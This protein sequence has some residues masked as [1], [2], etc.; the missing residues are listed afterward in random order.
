M[1]EDL[2]DGDQGD[3]DDADMNTLGAVC[4]EQG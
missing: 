1:T 4:E 3:A 2:E